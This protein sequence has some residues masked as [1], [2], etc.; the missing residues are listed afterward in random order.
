MTLSTSKISFLDYI[1]S[2]IHIIPI[3]HNLFAFTEALEYC[4]FRSVDVRNRKFSLYFQISILDLCLNIRSKK[5][6]KIY[7]D[8]C[9]EFITSHIREFFFK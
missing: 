1:L 4:I 5:L 8:K 7:V 2:Y 9:G 3:F 6:L